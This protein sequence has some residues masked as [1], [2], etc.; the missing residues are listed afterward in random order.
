MT[1][2]WVWKYLDHTF[3]S[4]RP[5]CYRA[6]GRISQPKKDSRKWMDG[7]FIYGNKDAQ[8]QVNNN[9]CK[10]LYINNISWFLYLWSRMSMYMGSCQISCKCNDWNCQHVLYISK[11]KTTNRINYCW[12]ASSISSVN[13]HCKWLDTFYEHLVQH[14]FFF[15]H[16]SVAI[17]SFVILY[18][19]LKTQ[20]LFL[21][22]S[23][24]TYKDLWQ[25]FILCCV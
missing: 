15:L 21:I 24:Y 8:S 1:Q 20:Y 25:Y 12:N 7:S 19:F 11:K 17:F 9:D 13:G 5:S 4:L 14:F 2:A 16:F 22:D 3:H 18:Q 6:R 23:L 10:H